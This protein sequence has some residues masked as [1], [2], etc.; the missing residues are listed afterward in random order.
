MAN[1]ET[2]ADRTA[3]PA[4]AMTKVAEQAGTAIDIKGLQKALN[5]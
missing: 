4:Y 2:M 5:L 3:S 1:S